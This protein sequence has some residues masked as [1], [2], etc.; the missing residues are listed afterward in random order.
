MS[1]TIKVEKY[2]NSP[3][4]NQASFNIFFNGQ[5]MREDGLPFIDK[6]PD[7]ETP[8]LLDGYDGF[9]VQVASDEE[10]PVDVRF[11]D[12]GGSSAQLMPA[13]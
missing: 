5:P 2:P 12:W 9:Y 13:P 8:P 11:R 4:S 10:G 3:A 7:F 6:Y 1:N